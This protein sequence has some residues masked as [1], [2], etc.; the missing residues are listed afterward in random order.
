MGVYGCANEPRTYEPDVRT[1][2][3]YRPLMCSLK[4][5][6]KII[7]CVYTMYTIVTALF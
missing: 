3:V 7:H 5:H 2:R 1:G 4:H 6:K